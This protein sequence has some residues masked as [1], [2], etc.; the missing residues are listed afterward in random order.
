M[1]KRHILILL[2]LLL[3]ILIATGCSPQSYS[4]PI[5]PNGG[6]WDRYFVFPMAW[7]LDKSSKTL[8][9]NYGL[10]ILAV[11]LI[12]RFATLPLM[13]KQLRSSKMMQALQPELQK[14]KEKYKDNQQKVQEETMKLFQKHNV[15]PLSGCLPLLVQM[16]IL[17]AFYQAIMRDPS[18]GTSTFLWLNLG[19]ADP[20]YI[21][22][23]LAAVT[24]YLQTKMMGTANNNPQA[25]MMLYIMPAMI[26]FIAI[27]LPS[28]LSLYWVYGN[29]FT[30]IQT[31]F[32]RDQYH[33][34]KQ[35][36]TVK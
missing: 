19:Q 14:I 13:I 4:K 6:F 33:G 36:G 30:I 28:A 34:Q 16:P 17:I 24:T 27:T 29:I 1:Q 8:F 2:L 5:D 25:Q 32:M 21:L 35:E 22:P 20:Y 12:V 7:L 10:G 15:N 31:Y 3:L 23:L 18:V 9:N 11:T 26:L